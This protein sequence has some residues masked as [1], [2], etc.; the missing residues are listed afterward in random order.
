MEPFNIRI[1]YNAR[2]VTLTILP[3]TDRRFTIVYFGGV[4][5]A[6]QNI[7]D[8]WELI[9]PR[10]IPDSGL[11]DYRMGYK[12][13]RTEIELTAEVAQYIGIKIAAFLSDS[14]NE[15]PKTAPPHRRKIRD[16]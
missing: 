14:I 7:G 8:I 10:F 6:V 9:D 1:N 12:N 2:E 4:L 11:P 15:L 5:G 13:S 16:Q 3:E